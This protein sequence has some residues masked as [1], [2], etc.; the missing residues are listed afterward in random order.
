MQKGEKRG[1]TDA[2]FRVL[3]SFVETLESKSFKKAFAELDE[4]HKHAIIT[5]L[6]NETKYMGGAIPYDFVKKLE[7]ALYGVITED[8]DKERIDFSR[9]TNLEKQLQKEN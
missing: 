6:E 8:D 2:K 1:R 9:K 3:K 4:P 7:E 5:R